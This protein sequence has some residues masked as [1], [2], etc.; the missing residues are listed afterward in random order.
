MNMV[1]VT[2]Y[3]VKDAAEAFTPSGVRKLTVDC[4]VENPV[5]DAYPWRCEFVSPELI[6]R[7]EP[8]L[9]AG[10]S[11]IFNGRLACRPYKERDVIKSI[12]KFLLVDEAEFPSRSCPKQEAKEEKQ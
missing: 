4:I 1:I 10:R 6:R 5:G 9:T 12:T 11:F 2:G 3:L 7:V 8:L